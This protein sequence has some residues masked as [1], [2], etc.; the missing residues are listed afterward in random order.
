VATSDG[1]AGVLAF[2]QTH[3]HQPAV[4][5]YSLDGVA[6]ELEL[7]DHGRWEVKPGRAQRGQRHGLLT[8]TPQPLKR[9]AMLRLNERHPLELSAPR[10]GASSLSSA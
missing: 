5:M 10:I 6:V 3:A 8:R 4:L 9:Q 7:T 2:N 1:P